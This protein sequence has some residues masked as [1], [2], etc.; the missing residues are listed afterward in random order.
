MITGGNSYFVMVPVIGVICL[1]I[2]F[3]IKKYK[4]KPNKASKIF[5]ED[6]KSFI[7]SWKK[8]SK[9]GML[10]YTIK[11]TTIITAIL[12][13]LFTFI[14]LNKFSMDEY[15]QQLFAILRICVMLGFFTSLLR[16]CVNSFRYSELED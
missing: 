7:K 4:I 13:I 2:Q 1:I 15:K 9:K 6:D 11:S 12:T 5:Y 3:L 8:I 10:R 16:W 14:I